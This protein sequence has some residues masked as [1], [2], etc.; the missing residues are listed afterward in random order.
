MFT[1]QCPFHIWYHTV[2][3]AHN[4]GES[5]FPFLQFGNKILAG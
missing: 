3:I 1:Q 2:L 5:G 4:A